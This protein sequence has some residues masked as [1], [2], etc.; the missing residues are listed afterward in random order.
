MTPVPCIQVLGSYSGK[1]LRK[2]LLIFQES[3]IRTQIVNARCMESQKSSDFSSRQMISLD[4]VLC[5]C[6]LPLQMH[7]PCLTPLH[8]CLCGLIKGF[9]RPPLLFRFI[10]REA[11]TNTQ[12]TEQQD[13]VIYFCIFPPMGIA[14][15]VMSSCQ[16]VL[17]TWPLLLWGLVTAPSS[18]R[19]SLEW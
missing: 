7:S 17:P 10:Q 5:V 8:A 2:S 19:S 1:I 11:S 16:R 15:P 4:L 9:F 6:H 14:S 18:L 3:D 12:K 13:C